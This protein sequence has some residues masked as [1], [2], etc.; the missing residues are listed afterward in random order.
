VYGNPAFVAEFGGSCVG[1]P[2]VEAL[3]GLPS[4]AF[5]LLDLAYREGRALAGWVRVDGVDRR[6]VVAVRRDIETNDVY[7]LAIHLVTRDRVAG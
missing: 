4:G 5:E 1:M 6:L 7:G 3:T 2:A